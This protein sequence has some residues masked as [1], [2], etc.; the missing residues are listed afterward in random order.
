MTRGLHE[1]GGAGEK[2]WSYLLER[3][4]LRLDLGEDESRS[5][6][7]RNG[8]DENQNVG[9][10]IK[11][12]AVQLPGE[13]IAP[14]PDV[15]KADIERDPHVGHGQHAAHRHER[16]HHHRDNLRELGGLACAREEQAA[17]EGREGREGED[18]AHDDRAAG[19]RAEDVEESG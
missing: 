13:E 14:V 6:E 1:W 11:P 19:D 7:R 18:P 3:R 12:V 15:P 5:T 10:G 17:G 2:A 4:V 9:H 16:V 8:P